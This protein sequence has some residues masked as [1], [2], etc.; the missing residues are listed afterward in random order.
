[1]RTFDKC[2]EN[3]LYTVPFVCFTD[4]TVRYK[5]DGLIV[6]SVAGEFFIGSGNGPETD[7][8]NITVNVTF[9]PFCGFTIQLVFPTAQSA[10]ANNTPV[11][12]GLNQTVEFV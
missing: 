4:A 12:L 7:L 3:I 11:M 5:I 8:S 6:R 10:S 2:Q 9:Y 1:M